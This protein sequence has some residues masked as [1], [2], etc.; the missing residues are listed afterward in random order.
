LSLAEIQQADAALR[1]LSV[2]E[3][4]DLIDLIRNRL[5]EKVRRH[6]RARLSQIRVSEA[7]QGS[8]DTLIPLTEEELKIVLEHARTVYDALA[9][10]AAARG[11]QGDIELKSFTRMVWNP[12]TKSSEERTYGP[13]AYIRLWATG[14]GRDRKR[15]VL[16]S[17]YVGKEIAAAKLRGWV[18]DEEVLKAYHDGTLPILTEKLKIRLMQPPSDSEPPDETDEA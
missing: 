16:K 15:T 4:R 2:D 8:L 11:G 10:A 18:T 14:G 3:L 13:Y 12:D 1:Q 7:L 9:P 5:G 6:G 17:I